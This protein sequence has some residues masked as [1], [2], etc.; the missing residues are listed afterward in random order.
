M[1][2]SWALH[3]VDS[4]TDDD[5]RVVVAG[6][7]IIHKIESPGLRCFSY[8]VNND[9]ITL[10]ETKNVDNIKQEESNK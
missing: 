10:W 4:N 1:F 6:N 2:P 7:I 9:N 5:D 3:G 8:N